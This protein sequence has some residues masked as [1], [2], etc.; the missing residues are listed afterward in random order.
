MSFFDFCYFNLSYMILQEVLWNIKSMSWVEIKHT[1]CQLP[2]FYLRT[3]YDV[4]TVVIIL[5]FYFLRIMSLSK[6]LTAM[7][8][9][10]SCDPLYLGKVRTWFLF[11]KDFGP[12][13]LGINDQL[14]NY[15]C[16]FR[17]GESDRDLILMISIVFLR[18][19]TYETGSPE[20]WS[21]QKMTRM[22]LDLFCWFHCL[23][24]L[25]LIY[26]FQDMQ[27]FCNFDPKCEVNICDGKPGSAMN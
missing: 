19:S 5:L 15:F 17:P 3:K 20:I 25:L 24:F 4:A 26:L 27:N 7:D 18:S 14:T 9:L 6:K 16:T 8:E 2:Y 12:V 22:I 13:Y 11:C 1:A 21:E 23:L 10:I